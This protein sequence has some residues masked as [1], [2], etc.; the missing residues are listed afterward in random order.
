MKS[1]LGWCHSN[2]WANNRQWHWQGQ[3]KGTTHWWNG[4][5]KRGIVG[6]CW[7]RMRS[8]QGSIVVQAVRT[9]NSIFHQFR[10]LHLLHFKR[11]SRWRR[12]ETRWRTATRML[13]LQVLLVGSTTTAIFCRM[14][15]NFGR[16]F[17]VGAFARSTYLM[18]SIFEL[19]WILYR[20]G[21][22]NKSTVH[23]ILV[24]LR[25]KVIIHNG[26]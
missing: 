10:L 13:I 23:T 12:G 8:I 26:L 14:I 3:L 11:G 1:V 4:K 17:I 7:S 22:Y 24:G 5:R 16:I 25:T 20:R 21:W 19:T 18:I 9:L 15:L 6:C 2:W